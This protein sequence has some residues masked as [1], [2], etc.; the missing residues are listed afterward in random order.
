MVGTMT[1]YD[2]AG[3]P[4]ETLHLANAPEDGKATF[5]SRMDREVATL[6]T[7]Y[8][9]ALWVAVSG[10]ASDLRPEL[11]KHCGRFLACRGICRRRRSGHDGRHR[12]AWRNHRPAMD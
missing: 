5:L 11:E 1:L 6:K 9:E 8:P 3:G 12:S 2:S 10:G 7:R 4:L